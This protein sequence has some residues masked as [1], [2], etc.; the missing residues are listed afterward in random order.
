MLDGNAIAG[1]LAEIFG[2][3]MTMRRATCANCGASGPIA[4][5]EVYMRAPGIVVR[6]RSCQTALVVMVER[7]GVYCTDLRGIAVM[8][9]AAG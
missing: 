5:T 3:D 4:E 6:C 7:R 9:A 2:G 8:G 1:T